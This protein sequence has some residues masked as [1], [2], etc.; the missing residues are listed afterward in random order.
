M[1]GI[2]GQFDFSDSPS[3]DGRAFVST[4]C[5]AIAH[6]GPDDS[7]IYESHDRRVVLGHQ[8]LSI[9]DL[10]PSGHQPMQNEDGRIWLTFNGEIYNHQQFRPELVRKGHALRSTS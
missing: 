4:A 6:R 2:V 10:S 7:G 8:R 9:V 1:C 5:A 3:G